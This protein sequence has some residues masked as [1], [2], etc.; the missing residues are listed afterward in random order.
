MFPSLTGIGADGATAI[1]NA[2]KDNTALTYLSFIGSNIEAKGAVA[3]AE[4]LENNT[5]FPDLDLTY[6]DRRGA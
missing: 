2:L 3:L 1:A 6:N 5:A 4:M